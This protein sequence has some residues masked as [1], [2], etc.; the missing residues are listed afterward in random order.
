VG[1]AFGAIMNLWFWPF[2]AYGPEA[3]YVAGDTFTANLGRYLLFYVTTSLPWD[4]GR[5][6]LSLLVLLLA[7]GALLR[8]LRRAS[9]RA[10][11]DA[12]VEFSE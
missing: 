1:L 11:F 6:V 2:A 10:A 3:S 7:G 8:A 5:G 4:L 12:V 9:R